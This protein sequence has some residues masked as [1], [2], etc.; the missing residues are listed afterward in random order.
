L[1]AARLMREPAA[2]AE[3]QAVGT[4]VET[5]TSKMSI[6]SFYPA[7]RASAAALTSIASR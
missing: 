2:A 1:I 6:E 4:A 7:D 3:P 5:T